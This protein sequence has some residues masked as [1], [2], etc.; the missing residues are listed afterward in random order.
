MINM[1]E[2]IREY[3]KRN[4]TSTFVSITYLCKIIIKCVIV[5][6]NFPTLVVRKVKEV[7]STD[8]RK[9][10]VLNAISTSKPSL[11]VNELPLSDV[12]YEIENR[13]RR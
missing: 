6:L 2:L 13:P 4:G 11:S 8:F 9:M 7:H 12:D 5:R 3:V 10:F 1:Y